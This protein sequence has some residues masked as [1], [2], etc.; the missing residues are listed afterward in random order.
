MQSSAGLSPCFYISFGIFSKAPSRL[1]IPVLNLHPASQHS[2][3]A[4]AVFVITLLHWA[5]LFTFFF[6]FSQQGELWTEGCSTAWVELTLFFFS[7]SRV[8]PFKESHSVGSQSFSRMHCAPQHHVRGGGPQKKSLEG[9]TRKKGW[10]KG[11]P[12]QLSFPAWQVLAFPPLKLFQVSP[13]VILPLCLFRRKWYGEYN[14][15][16][17]LFG[18]FSYCLGLIAKN[19]QLCSSLGRRRNINCLPGLC[20]KGCS[21]S[22]SWIFAYLFTDLSLKTWL[23]ILLLLPIAETRIWVSGVLLFA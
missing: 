9:E 13:S 10:R 14:F 7:A 3:S 6:F 23:Q 12:Q 22:C 8:L 5:K 16:W 20:Q 19:R 15:W 21:K 1:Q 18:S 17:Q 2:P 11:E 4:Q